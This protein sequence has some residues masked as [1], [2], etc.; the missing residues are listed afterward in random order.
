M[1]TVTITASGAGAQVSPT[2]TTTTVAQPAIALDEG[3][4]AMNVGVEPGPTVDAILALLNALGVRGVQLDA[5]PTGV[6]PAVQVGVD[7][8]GAVS[9]TA[10]VASCDGDKVCLWSQANFGGKRVASTRF[11]NRCTDIERG[12]VS[13]VSNLHDRGAVY[14]VSLYTSP[15]PADKRFSPDADSHLVDMKQGQSLRDFGERAKSFTIENLSTL[16]STIGGN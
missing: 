3:N 14:K 2:T 7:A 6:L 4:V 11:T 15:C 10:N 13:G 8:S 9:A 12:A 1:A 16:P 5:P